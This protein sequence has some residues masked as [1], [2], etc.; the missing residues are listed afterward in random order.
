MVRNT[1]HG[2]TKP[3]AGVCAHGMQ[4]AAQQK[5]ALIYPKYHL[6]ADE[7]AKDA[8]DGH[9]CAVEQEVPG[10]HDKVVGAVAQALQRAVH[11]G[12]G[13]SWCRQPAILTLAD[14]ARGGQCLKCVHRPTSSG[15][16]M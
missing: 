15:T 10:P 1:R 11:D 6:E 2:R 16:Q 9:E 7:S 14:H 12:R 3:P 8:E 4:V 13:H 5:A